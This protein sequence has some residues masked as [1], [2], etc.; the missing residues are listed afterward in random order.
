MFPRSLLPLLF[1]A[2]G[3][4]V[5]PESFVPAG[6]N[7]HAA[8]K[9]EFLVGQPRSFVILGDETSFVWPTLLQG[10]LDAHAGKRE[11]YRVVNG[12]VAGVEVSAWTN[13]DPDGPFRALVDDCLSV[14]ARLR[15]GG[16]P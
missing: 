11:L 14:R 13:A 2:T 7:T 4:H 16:T 5:R 9:S 8:Q 6:A 1:F 15:P 10:L 12:S 3:C